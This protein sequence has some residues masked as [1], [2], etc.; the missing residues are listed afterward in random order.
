MA[1]TTLAQINAALPGQWFGWNKTPVGLASGAWYSSWTVAGAPGQGVAPSSGVA[2][3]VPTSATAGAIPFI[4]PTA[5]N[6]HIGRLEGAYVIAGNANPTQVAVYDRLWHDSGIDVTLTTAQ[7]IQSA[8]PVAVPLTRPDALGAQVEA[9][10]EV[11]ATMGAGTPTVTLT[12]TDQDGN[13][14]NS[15]S[16]GALGTTMP[17]GRTGRFSLASGDTGV[18]SIQTWQANATFTSGT[19]GLVQRRRL[20][21]HELQPSGLPTTLDAIECGVPRVYDDACLEVLFFASSSLGFTASLQLFLA[22]G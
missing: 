6:T 4:N 2:G 3:N 22:Q 13:T 17:L 14:G 21:C 15:G 12:Y 19:I 18:R 16:S 9:W 8:P 7:T 11:Y 1:F 5:Q 10:W 20:L